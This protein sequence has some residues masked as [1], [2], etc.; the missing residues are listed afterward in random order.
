M[1]EYKHEALAKLE[2]D[3]TELTTKHEKLERVVKQL[4]LDVAMARMR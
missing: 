2:N 3:I 4:Q 1:E